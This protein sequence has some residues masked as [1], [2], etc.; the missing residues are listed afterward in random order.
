[1]D[2]VKYLESNPSFEKAVLV[3]TDDI[4]GEPL[5]EVKVGSSWVETPDDVFRAWTG[6]RRINGDEYHGPVFAFG[7]EVPYGGSRVC[8]CR[9]CEASVEPRNRKN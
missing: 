7:T 9:E 3:P 4:A 1:M 5:L 2:K 6:E 8:A